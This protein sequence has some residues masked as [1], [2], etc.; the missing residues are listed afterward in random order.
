MGHFES[1]LG[2]SKFWRVALAELN[3]T[4]IRDADEESLFSS[5]GSIT[6]ASSMEDRVKA[7]LANFPC[8]SF[9]S[10]CPNAAATIASSA[11]VKS[12]AAG[13]RIAQVGDTLD[14]IVI[15]LRG[16]VEVFFEA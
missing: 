15:I 16:T 7:L 9:A 1:L 8:L 2:S 6:S 12:F 5:V 10:P 4:S 13:D 11:K 3:S 14:N